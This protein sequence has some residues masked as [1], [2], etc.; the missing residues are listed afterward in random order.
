VNLATD[1][2]LVFDAL[3]V[4]PAVAFADHL[5]VDL[6]DPH[7]DVPDCAGAAIAVHDPHLD[8]RLERSAG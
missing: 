1:Q 8:R 4:H 6:T 3:P 7:M 5:P 2:T